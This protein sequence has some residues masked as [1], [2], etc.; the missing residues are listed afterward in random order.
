MWDLVKGKGGQV[1]TYGISRPHSLIVCI[2]ICWGLTIDLETAPMPMDL[3][4]SCPE[5]M[6]ED[7]RQRFISEPL[8]PV[9]GT[10]D[11]AGMERGEPGLPMW[12]K[13]SGLEMLH[14]KTKGQNRLRSTWHFKTPCPV[15]K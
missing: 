1:L 8:E 13:G 14:E 15:T 3:R 7:R 11:S 12:K 2:R 4:I 9:K 10:I 6:N 5:I